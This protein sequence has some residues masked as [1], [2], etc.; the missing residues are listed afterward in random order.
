[1][2]SPAPSSQPSAPGS[3][4][5]TRRGS[6]CLI[7]LAALAVVVAFLFRD[8][9]RSEM[10]MF[11]ND[12]P[13]GLV[14]AACNS[15]PQ[16]W[17]GIWADLNW[18][19]FNGGSMPPDL[20]SVLAWTL[21]PVHFIKFYPGITVIALGLAACLFFRTLGFHPVVCVLGG[22]AAALNTDFFSYACWGLGTL[23]LCVASVFLAFAALT[24]TRIP[25]WT[26]AILAG[27]ALGN[28]LMEGFDNGAIFSLYVAAFAI[29]HAWQ[30]RPEEK[31]S[32]RLGFGALRT[33]IVAVVS[34]LV[35][36]H[37]LISLVQLNI[38]S[39]AGMSQE[40]EDRAARWAFATQWSLP[41]GETLR[42]VIPG[43]YGYRMDTP[44]GGQYWG[45][46]G[47]HPVWDDYWASPNRANL[48]RP[49][50][51]L[52]YSGAGHYAGVLVVVMAVFAFANSLRRDG[53]VYSRTE[54]RWIWFWAIAAI[55]S[56]LFAFGRFAPFYHIIY[57][58]PYFNTIRNPV[59]FLHPFSVA[60]VV[61]FAYG[62]QA[63]WRGWIQPPASVGAA[64]GSGA[65]G[66]FASGSWERKW[67]IGLVAVTVLSA[68]AW[69]RYQSTSGTEALKRKLTEFGVHPAS[70]EEVARFSQGEVGLFVLVLIASTALV[71]LALNGVFRDGRARLAGFALGALLTLDLARANTPW[72]V[73][74]NWRERY[75]SNALFDLL[76]QDAHLA[77]VT[78]Q[79]PFDFSRLPREIALLLQQL[80]DIYGLEWL[81]HQFRYFN[82]QSL[83]VVQLPREPADRV[84]YRTALMGNPVREWE[85]SNTRRLLT[86]APLVDSLNAQLD[87]DQKRFRLLMAFGLAMTEDGVITVQTNATGPYGIIEFDGALPRAMLFDRWRGNVPD[88]EALKLLGSTNFNPHAEVLIA[89]PIP[90]PSVDTS[91]QPAGTA[92]YRSYAP[93]E[94]VIET[95]A[96]TPCVLLVNDRHDPNWRV[97]VDGKEEPLL[98]ANFIM[99]GVYLTPGKHEVEFRFDPPTGTLWLSAI[100]MMGGLALCVVVVWRARREGS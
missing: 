42:A 25:W 80:M 27:V 89:E 51:P 39:A 31:G 47:M 34:G 38:S 64:K 37:V 3:A 91:T 36:A 46:V 35:A 8:S 44:E 87:P 41:P 86:L 59:K 5:E 14:A 54:R 60:T 71:L 79:L 58:L 16:G 76:R 22:L 61:L 23:T 48:E 96:R 24:S 62:C 84:A 32:R 52:R 67:S 74:Y 19:G 63:L 65:G 50:A 12:G 13:L 55:L 69:M 56:L 49:R 94:F 18:L 26:G 93:K 72:I 85:L 88:E 90:A 28:A 10:A 83:E 99:R 95:D 1:M 40:Q 11:A 30:R 98:R 70:I 100:S 68:I 57:A 9:F 6:A 73:H 77:R 97:F 20:T 15:F 81:Q 43:L 2:R 4:S 78:G 17:S 92:A 33:A 53:L 82:I 7:L 66:A 21:G 45:R 29:F 75:Q